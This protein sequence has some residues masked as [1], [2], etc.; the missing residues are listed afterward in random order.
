MPI[1]FD[2]G[3]FGGG[4]TDWN[5]TPIDDP[6]DALN[7]WHDD[8]TPAPETGFWTWIETD[9]SMVEPVVWTRWIT[10]ADERV[11]P[12]CGPLDGQLWEDGSGPRPPL[13]VDCRCGRVHAFTEWR[14]RLATT[15]ELRWV[16]A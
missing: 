14:T 3:D 7:P 2:P 8:P 16:A 6:L 12:E 11:C 5:P 15:W 1:G 9:A 10:R 13:H 4:V